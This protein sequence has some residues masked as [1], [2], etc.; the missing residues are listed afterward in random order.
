MLN[1]GDYISIDGS[2]GAIYKGMIESADSEVK[3][4]LEGSLRPNSSYTYEL[5]QTVMKWADKHRS[6]KIRTNADTPGM[7]EQAVSFGA[8]VGPSGG[9]NRQTIVGQ[10]GSRR[11]SY[12]QCCQIE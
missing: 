8:E 10:N 11:R 6:L 1:E 9:A 4:V 2:T 12:N 5:F 3:R 7:A